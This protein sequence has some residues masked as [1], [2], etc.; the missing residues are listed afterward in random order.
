MNENSHTQGGWGIGALILGV[1]GLAGCFFLGGIALGIP[2]IGCGVV[3]V[4][5]VKQ[6]LASNLRVAVTGVIVSALSLILSVLLTA[7]F[8]FWA[9]G[10]ECYD[11]TG[12]P[13]D[14]EVQ[15]CLDE[16]FGTQ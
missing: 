12:Y 15:A 14:A 7:Y 2:G 4:R 16:T 5:R 9:P 10:S 3:G 11:P 8:L 13:T 6:G 1:G